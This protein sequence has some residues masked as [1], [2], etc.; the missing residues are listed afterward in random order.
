VTLGCQRFAAQ[1]FTGKLAGPACVGS[2]TPNSGS[3]SV[4]LP[5][6]TAVLVTIPN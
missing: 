3:Y 4:R 1:T 5:A 2:L 6:A